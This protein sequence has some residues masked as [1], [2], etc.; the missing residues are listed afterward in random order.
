MALATTSTQDSQGQPGMLGSA[1]QLV[2]PTPCPSHGM[3][4]YYTAQS[5]GCSEIDADPVQAAGAH[6]KPSMVVGLPTRSASAFSVR[7]SSCSPAVLASAL[8]LPVSGPY[9]LGPGLLLLFGT[10][11]SSC[12]AAWVT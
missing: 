9:S 12:K 7:S 4:R 11:P 6:L 2:P 5:T 10:S 1:W 3:Q 8:Q